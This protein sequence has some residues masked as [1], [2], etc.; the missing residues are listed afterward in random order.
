MVLQRSSLDK[1]PFFVGTFMWWRLFLNFWRVAL[2]KI[3]QIRTLGRRQN[4][5]I[6]ASGACSKPT[7]IV[8]I[9]LATI[10]IHHVDI[11]ATF[12]SGLP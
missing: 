9:H 7:N 6:R 4:K 8:D 12:S 2:G 1:M 11:S 3:S 5:S 10:S